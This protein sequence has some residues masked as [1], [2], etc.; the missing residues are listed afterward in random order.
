MV[1]AAGAV[2]LAPVLMDTGNAKRVASAFFGGRVDC[3]A[4]LEPE[5]PDY[6]FDAIV[7][8][9]AGSIAALDGDA[10]PSEAGQ[11]RLK[12]GARAYL[13]GYASRIILLDGAVGPGEKPSIS[14]KYLQRLLGDNA[15]M[16]PNE[17]ILEEHDSVNTA[18]NMEKLAEIVEE[19]GIRLVV[20][21]SSASHISRAT[22]LACAHGVK[23]ASLPAEDILIKQDPL[24][25]TRMFFTTLKEKFETLLLLVDTQGRFP[26]LF[27]QIQ[28][29]IP[30]RLPCP[31][32]QVCLSLSQ[33]NLPF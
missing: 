7:R 10:I 16:I 14:K 20:I 2:I 8:P 24:P 32:W 28:N 11:I 15:R 27:K 12:A 30:D 17:A 13:A 6:R 3:T 23:A 9:G 29:Y 19:K 4:G 31:V 1:A 22:V 18:T 26:T 33:M 21:V 5:N 25:S